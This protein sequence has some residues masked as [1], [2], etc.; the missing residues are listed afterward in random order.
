[1]GPAPLTL[2]CAPATLAEDDLRLTMVEKQSQQEFTGGY[3]VPVQILV[4]THT[5]E[6]PSAQHMQIC[7]CEVPLALSRALAGYL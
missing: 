3:Q 5:I 4:K 1:M 6:L 2:F 7:N